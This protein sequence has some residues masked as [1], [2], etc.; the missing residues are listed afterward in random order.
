MWSLVPEKLY[1]WLKNV[2]TSLLVE[3]SLASITGMSNCLM[4]LY[5]L[6]MLDVHEIVYK[7]MPQKS[8]WQHSTKIWTQKDLFI[9]AVCY[10][11]HHACN[12]AWPIFKCHY[13]FSC[14]CHF[15]SANVYFLHI[16][17]T[18]SAFEKKQKKS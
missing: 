17:K 12:G 18:L 13:I 5:T 6:N 15:Q 8:R 16:L 1:R 14:L 10:T 3:G 9:L 7:Y 2:N 11:V 4:L